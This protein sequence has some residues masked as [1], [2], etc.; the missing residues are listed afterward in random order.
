MNLG[1][2]GDNTLW[3]AF[4][5][6]L[7][8]T[9]AWLFKTYADPNDDRIWGTLYRGLVEHSRSTAVSVLA[10]LI[11]CLIYYETNQLVLASGQFNYVAVLGS[12]FGA[13]AIVFTFLGQKLA[14]PMPPADNNKG[15]TP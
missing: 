6:G 14:V 2:F 8:G 5:I 13:Q 7:L 1:A 10:H 3:K 11:L 12:G 9:A 15:G 4:F